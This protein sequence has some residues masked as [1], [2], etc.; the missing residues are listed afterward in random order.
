MCRIKKTAGSYL[1]YLTVRKVTY[2]LS[3]M[4]ITSPSSATYYL[5][6][7]FHIH[8]NCTALTDLSSPAKKRKRDDSRVHTTGCART[9]GFYKI[10]VREKAKHKVTT[11]FI[12]IIIM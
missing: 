3:E 6:L 5:F 9:E 4:L 8:L 11:T 7:V 2:V 12:I 10:D 1:L